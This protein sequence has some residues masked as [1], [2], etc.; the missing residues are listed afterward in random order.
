MGAQA[1]CLHPFLGAQA[2]L[3]AFF[4]G[5][6]GILACILSWERRHPC[7]H[8]FA[9][10]AGI[11]ACILSLGSAGILPAFIMRKHEAVEGWHSR[12]YLPH[13]DGP[14]ITQFVTFRLYDSIPQTVFR[15]W[16]EEL[17][18]LTKTNGDAILRRRL[19]LYLDQGYG[20]CYLRDPGVAELVQKS[21]LFFDDERYK[22][23]AWVVMP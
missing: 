11:L 19:E 7:L 15:K 20:N 16:G 22:L 10:S 4:L 9:G 17:R 21:F 13:F 14:Q 8:S 6:A 5:S 23:S 12:G 18:S 3:P 1:S 2:S